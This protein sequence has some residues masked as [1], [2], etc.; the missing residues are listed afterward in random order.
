[1]KMNF[2]PLLAFAAL[3]VA[4]CDPIGLFE[5]STDGDEAV[6]RITYYAWYGASGNP[7]LTLVAT[8]DS[9]IVVRRAYN[10][11]DNTI[12]STVC[13][14]TIRDSEWEALQPGKHLN[15]F[16]KQAE[17]AMGFCGNSDVFT[18]TVK[19]TLREGIYGGLEA[20]L[21]GAAGEIN[22]KIEKVLGTFR[23]KCE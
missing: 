13:A 14:R 11:D 2:L 12:D 5:R 15:P 4:A 22:Q 21:D 3:F 16:F 23:D 19:T 8:P 10:W 1:M 20:G 17:K 9:V 18:L 7:H 6:K